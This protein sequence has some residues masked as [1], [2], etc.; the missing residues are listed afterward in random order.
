MSETIYL[1][2]TRAELD[3][4]FDQRAWARNAE[5]IIARCTRESAA[6]RARLE[7]RA[8]VRFGPGESQV[9]DIFPAPQP[10][11]AVQIFV[12][13]GAWRAFTKDDYSF[14]AQ[15]F[16]PSGIHTV[17]LS[18]DNLPAVRL[19]EMVAQVRR[20]M[21]WV[22][23]NA[24]T[25]GGDPDRL[26]VTAH[27]SGAHLA[28]MALEG[29]AAAPDVPQNFVKGAL[30]ACGP[31]YLEPVV[32]SARSAYVRL[33]AGEVAALSPG[34]H[35]GRISCPV[36]LACA[37]YDTDEFQ[38]Q[39]REFAEALRRAGRL[40]GAVRFAGLNHFELMEKFGDPGHPLVRAV[41]EQMDAA[42]APPAEPG[43]R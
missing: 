28:A 33:E 40:R 26:Y 21:E 39:W 7:L 27:S 29:W 25:F 19:P 2:Y 41:L 17:V 31:Y 6:A 32:L 43:R 9:L 14:A 16:V 12:H 42:G 5:E 23:R 15:G 8:G 36:T 30:L 10:T 35:A 38:R 34:L 24:R 11:G 22:Y 18:F 20:G 3:R 4:N 13:G 37:E 1:H